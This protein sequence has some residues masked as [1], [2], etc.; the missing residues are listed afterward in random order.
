MHGLPVEPGREAFRVHLLEGTC[1]LW[2]VLDPQVCIAGGVVVVGFGRTVDTDADPV[3]PLVS[4]VVV[5]QPIPLF[6][7]DILVINMEGP[8]NAVRA[9]TPHE[10]DDMAVGIAEAFGAIGRRVIAIPASLPTDDGS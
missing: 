2:V 5:L 9:L 10:V 3:D 8:E 4:R 6:F 7:R 1:E